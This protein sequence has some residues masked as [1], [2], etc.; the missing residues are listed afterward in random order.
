MAIVPR[1]PED[2]PRLAPAPRPATREL[3]TPRGR[4][5]G[6]PRRD[7]GPH[8]SIGWISTR[9]PEGAICA[10]SVSS[11]SSVSSSRGRLSPARFA[12]VECLRHH[13]AM[14]RRGP[15]SSARRHA[16][17]WRANSEVSTPYCSG[18]TTSSSSS[19]SSRIASCIHS[20]SARTR[21]DRGGPGS[22]APLPPTSRRTVLI[23]GVSSVTGTPSS[24]TPSMT[25]S[26]RSEPRP[27]AR[28]YEHCKRAHSPS[29]G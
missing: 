14:V 9:E 5:A 16:G 4:T 13:R 6:A 19:L 20:A 18:A 26:P 27:S 28:Q 3:S 7:G 15:S 23:S 8:R 12:V 21:P 22:L 25:C 29:E 11:R 10:S 24:R 2:D 1:L 17:S